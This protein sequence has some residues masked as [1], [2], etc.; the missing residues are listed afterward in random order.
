MSV[1]PSENYAK[2]H[3]MMV[4]YPPEAKKKPGRKKK[5][6]FAK[7]II[8]LRSIV[9][10]KKIIFASKKLIFTKF[11]AVFVSKYVFFCFKLALR[12][13]IFLKLQTSIQ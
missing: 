13:L 5:L 1:I 12:N 3:L 10:L 6:V 8:S 7:L 11:S 9:A 2:L 4:I